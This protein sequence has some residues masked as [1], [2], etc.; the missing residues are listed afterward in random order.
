MSDVCAGSGAII[1][2]LSLSLSLVGISLSAQEQANGTR[3]R[4]GVPEKQG[5]KV[6]ESKGESKGQEERRDG[7]FEDGFFWATWN[8]GRRSLLFH[9]NDANE[10]PS[11]RHA[12][13]VWE[14][15]RVVD[16][17]LHPHTPLSLSA[18][19]LAY[20]APPVCISRHSI[21]P[22]PALAS[23]PSCCHRGEGTRPGA[24]VAHRLYCLLLILLFSSAD[25]GPPARPRSGAGEPIQLVN[26]LAAVNH[27]GTLSEWVSCYRGRR[28]G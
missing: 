6:V 1:S 5:E 2:C 17:D 18:C 20:H 16:L 25:K 4:A 22:R 24:C 12:R 19:T 11:R 26:S 14:W 8:K 15:G 10:P 21:Q 23:L 7:R 13:G 9:P 28:L 27:R 3:G